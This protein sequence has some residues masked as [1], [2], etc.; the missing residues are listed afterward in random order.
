MF[1]NAAPDLIKAGVELVAKV[2]KLWRS[3]SIVGSA[4]EKKIAWVLC[5]ERLAQL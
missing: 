5:L 2:V 3:S 4:D 1:V